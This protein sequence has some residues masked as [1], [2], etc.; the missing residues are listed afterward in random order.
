[1]LKTVL[2]RELGLSNFVYMLSQQK[3]LYVDLVVQSLV[4]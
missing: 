2:T 4:E 1:M 3:C